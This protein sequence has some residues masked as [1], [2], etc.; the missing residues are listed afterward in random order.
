MVNVIFLSFAVLIHIATM[1]RFC[2][3]FLYAEKELFKSYLQKKPSESLSF[4][5][6]PFVL[7]VKF[8]KLFKLK[9]LMTLL[10]FYISKSYRTV[11]YCQFKLLLL[12]LFIIVVTMSNTFTIQ[13][14]T[15]LLTHA[16]AFLLVSK[17]KCSFFCSTTIKGNSKSILSYVENVYPLTFN[18]RHSQ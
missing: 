1:M 6:L 16:R 7:L 9:K 3:E 2:W 14:Y 4:L 15:F 13:E 12:E 8:I 18:L 11:R 10:P 5:I 17:I